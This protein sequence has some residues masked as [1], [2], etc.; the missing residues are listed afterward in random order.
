VVTLFH[1]GGD[2]NNHPAVFA[3]Y[4]RSGIWAAVHVGQFACMAILLAGLFALFFA[5]DVQA[6]TARWAG[7]F[8]AALAAVTLAL[9]GGVLAVDGVALKQAVDAWASAPD[10]DKA[11]RFASAEAIRWLE[12]GMRSYA[13]FAL[14]LAVLLFAVAVVRTAWVPR[15][16]AYFMGLA[17]LTDLVQ[18]WLAGS[19]GFSPTHTFAIVLA[20]VLN[21]AWMIWLVVIGWRMR[22][23]EPVSPGRLGEHA[24][25]GQDGGEN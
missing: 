24:V 21:L 3:G 19:E 1:A 10:A 23:S 11:A 12:W 4:A 7:R 18:G 13:S 5:L 15:P 25:A 17:G 16:I 9:Y 22:D 6:G 8:G 20:E 2:A 14:G